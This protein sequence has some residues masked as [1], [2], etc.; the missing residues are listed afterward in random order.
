[1]RDTGIELA[2]R[3]ALRPKE[4]AEAL[5]VGE[6]TLRAWMKD[7]ELPFFRVNG[8]VRIPR[9]ALEEWMEERETCAAKIEAIANEI[10]RDIG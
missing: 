1:M 7:E 2:D 5:G 9:R 4:A 3:L 10:I 6:R 8:V